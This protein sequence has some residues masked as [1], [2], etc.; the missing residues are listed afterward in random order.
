MQELFQHSYAAEQPLFSLHIPKCGGQSL[1]SI[2]RLWFKEA[3][4]EVYYDERTG[5][6][7]LAP[8][9]QRGSVIHGHFSDELAIHRLYPE[10]DQF[11]TII[12]DPFDIVVSNYFYLKRASADWLSKPDIPAS[13][14]AYLEQAI[15]DRFDIVFNFLPHRGVGQSMEAFIRATFLRVVLC[16]EYQSSV[17]ILADTLNKPR[18]AVP[19]INESVRD[20]PIPNLREAFRQVY[21]EEYEFFDLVRAEHNRRL[22]VTKK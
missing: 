19:R 1:A 2:L 13:L 7:P 15:A 4:H 5:I 8:M 9:P 6:Q 14:A 22:A 16:E 18:V 11:I 10:A 12:R 17:D 21:T 20:E 3:F